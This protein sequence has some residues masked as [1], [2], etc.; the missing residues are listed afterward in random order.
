MHGATIT[1]HSPYSVTNSTWFPRGV[2][3]ENFIA[4]TLGYTLVCAVLWPV[5]LYHTFPHYLINGAIL[6]NQLLNLKCVF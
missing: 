2:K 6:E 3:I 4:F 1:I 5:G